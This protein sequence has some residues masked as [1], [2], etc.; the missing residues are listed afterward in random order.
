MTLTYNSKLFNIRVNDA[1]QDY[2]VTVK[3]FPNGRIEIRHYDRTLSR[4]KDGLI[5]RTDELAD[6]IYNNDTKT[7]KAVRDEK[8]QGEH[9]AD[10]LGRS[11][12][13]LLDYVEYNDIW[14]SF[15]TLTFAKNITD[16]DIANNEFAKYI[17][18]IKRINPNFMYLG[19]PEFQK[20]GAVHY[21]ILTNLVIGSDLIPKRE[22]KKTFNKDKNTYYN[23]EY[24]DLPYWNNGF[25]SAFDFINDSD[26]NFNL[27]A[28]MG[29]YFFKDIDNRLFGRRKILKSQGLKKPKVERF[30]NDDVEVVRLIETLR[31]TEFYEK[32]KIKG[33]AAKRP[34]APNFII[35]NYKL[36][37]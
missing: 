9:R 17:R 19:V 14:T 8:G 36:K 34:Q 26:S 31:N 28:Y 23:L 27:S 24:Y 11:F 22:P 6:S 21:H 25:S 2:N 10:N 7:K 5:A 16:L 12:G 30:L 29:K 4:L 37:V 3:K 15:I 18:K 32:P 20:R 33:V 35:A 1:Y 13:Q